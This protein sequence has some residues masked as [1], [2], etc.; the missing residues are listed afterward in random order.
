MA[1][2]GSK[3]PTNCDS[4]PGWFGINWGQSDY[5]IS[6]GCVSLTDVILIP[7]VGQPVPGPIPTWFPLAASYPPTLFDMEVAASDN[8]TTQYSQREPGDYE[9]DLRFADRR[10]TAS[11]PGTS[12]RMFSGRIT[13]VATGQYLQCEDEPDSSFLIPRG[14]AVSNWLDWW[15]IDPFA[16]PIGGRVVDWNLP[17]WTAPTG[18]PSNY[19]LAMVRV[20]SRPTGWVD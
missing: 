13:D 18:Q 11:F 19:T 9:V 1:R 17:G 10:I 14:F 7:E 2:Y 16:N 20:Q 15:Q 5:P 3:W 8:E 6:P 4:R 12:W